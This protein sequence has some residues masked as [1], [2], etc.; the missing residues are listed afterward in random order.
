MTRLK[1]QS[2]ASA[3]RCSASSRVRA[4]CICQ[5]IGKFSDS[6][7]RPAL[8]SRFFA[9]MTFSFSS[10]SDISVGVTMMLR[11]YFSTRANDS[12]LIAAT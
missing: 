8:I 11:P 7:A 4:R 9:S 5:F 2:S 10:G 12:G 6:G 3:G 1:Y